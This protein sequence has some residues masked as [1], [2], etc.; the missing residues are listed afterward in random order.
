M[1]ISLKTRPSLLPLP[2]GL[3]ARLRD[4]GSI[5]F[6]YALVVVVGGLAAFLSPNFREP[7]NLINILRQSIVLGLVAIGQSTVILAGG[8]DMS[9]GTIAKVSALTV[10][11][12]FGGNEALVIPLILLGLGLGAAIG[13]LNGLLITRLNA[14]PFIVT[15]GVFSI[16]RGIGLAI[17]SG[18]VGQIPA[19]FLQIYD[20]RV[21]GVPANVIGMALLWA[22]AWVITARTP[23]GRAIYAVGG[24]ARVARLSA[25]NVGRTLLGAYALSG[26]CGAAAGLFILSRTGVG[27]PSLG[28][29]LEFQS[30]VAVA[31]GG[32]SLYGGKGSLVGTLGGV[33]LLGLVAN[34]F[35]IL[36]V[37]VFHQQ[38]LL[39]LIVLVAVAAYKSTRSG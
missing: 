14:S 38:L 29:G 13:L 30:I 37:S 34:V 24:S 19:S 39:G 18:P 15:F 22:L 10:A 31:L 17:A 3:P 2:G 32:I 26:L 1:A 5:I 23:F 20:A 28:D 27:D 25:I 16:L 12:L 4:N 9:I 6:I 21:G 11:T 7:S 33:L 36:Q 8:I 35:N